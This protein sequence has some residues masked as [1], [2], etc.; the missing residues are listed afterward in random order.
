[1]SGFSYIS[2]YTHSTSESLLIPQI[3]QL[4]IWEAAH[5]SMP[6][7]FLRTNNGIC[8]MIKPC[9]KR[10]HLGQ[11]LVCARSPGKAVQVSANIQDALPSPSSDLPAYLVH[12]AYAAASNSAEAQTFLCSIS[13]HRPR[14]LHM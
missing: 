8:R 13:S 14:F 3:P 5:P 6:P 7:C 12:V 2:S 4:S 10:P 11:G 9:W 1:M